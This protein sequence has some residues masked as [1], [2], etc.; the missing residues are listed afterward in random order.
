MEVYFD[1]AATSRPYEEVID[2]VAYAMKH[3]YGNPSS[4]H[5]LGVEAQSKLDYAKEK[6]A[7]MINATK[8]EIIFTSGGSE[9]NNFL[10]RAFLKPNCH[11]ITS[12][13]E[14]L[15]ILNST[16]ALEAQG[17]N[18]TYVEV[19]SKGKIQIEK[20]QEAL[21]KDTVLVSIMAV[22]N[23]IG[24][25][26]DMETIGHIV[27][28]H[29]RAKF[30]VDAIQGYGKIDIDVKKN[31]IDLLSASGH[32]IHGPRGIGLAYVR[33]GLMP[34]PFIYGGGQEKGKRAGTENVAN[35]IGF[36]KACEI[37]KPNIKKNYDYVKSIKEYFIEGLN[38]IKE[39]KINSPIEDEFSPYILNVAF[40]G[41]RGE[42]LLHML[43][44]QGIY[45]STISACSSKNKKESYVLKAIGVSKEY[46]EGAIRFSFNE[47]NTK[48][49]VDY[50]LD[51]LE[52][53]LKFLRRIK[54]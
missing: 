1:N 5:R 17:I 52:K 28:N 10:L 49:E 3:Y 40:K 50:T 12:S 32:K 38:K 25:I 48:E 53:S 31:N 7:Q 29:G 37:I 42:V 36:A 51:I 2:E 44:E 43:E 22:N 27:K 26:E 18:V 23:E 8:E 4:V 46:M 35:A 45:V 30:H 21:R 16:K 6:V 9:S 39:I 15:S 20:L 13:I 41:I 34:T 14:H 11:I 54:I 47:T 33:K 24:T 19:D